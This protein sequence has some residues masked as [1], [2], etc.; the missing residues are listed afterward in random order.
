MIHYHVYITKNMF[1]PEEDEMI[2]GKHIDVLRQYL[3]RDERYQ[4][5]NIFV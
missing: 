3:G 2:D 4:L 1:P 5:L